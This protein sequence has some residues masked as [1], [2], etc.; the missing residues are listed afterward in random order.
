MK[1]QL[2]LV[3][4]LGMLTLCLQAQTATQPTTQNPAQTPAG[5]RGVQSYVEKAELAIEAKSLIPDTAVF[6][7]KTDTYVKSGE[8]K[9]SFSLESLRKNSDILLNK[10]LKESK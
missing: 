10:W 9:F 7:D 2:L 8:Y 5:F 4:A 3:F 6:Q 1:K